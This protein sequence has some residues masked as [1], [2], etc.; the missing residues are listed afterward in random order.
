ME[1]RAELILLC[2][3]RDHIR[4]ELLRL[5]RA[6][7]YTGDPLRHTGGFHGVAEVQAKLLPI[8]G[9][10]DAGQ[11]DFAVAVGGEMFDLFPQLFQ[12][13]GAHAAACIRDDAIRTETVASVFD[14]DKCAGALKKALDLHRFELRRLFVRDDV[15]DTLAG[16]E[17]LQNIRDKGVAVGVAQHDVGVGQLLRQ[18]REGLR[19]A[20]GQHND[21][22]G[23][24]APCTMQG[25]ADLV[26]AG[27]GDRTGIDQHNV[28]FRR[29]FTC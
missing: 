27:G 20:T 17:V 6:E 16:G 21:S 5:Q 10:I 9:E 28:A 13:L 2:K 8:G 15:H 4:A 26:I 23:I 1:L 24:S 25:L 12:G 11:H 29:A 22:A 14:F 18:F 3:A 19:H 7:A